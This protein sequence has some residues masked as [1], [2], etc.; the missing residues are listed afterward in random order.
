MAESIIQGLF[1]PTPYQLQQQHQAQLDAS[2]NAYAAQDPFQRATAGF[3]RAGGQAADIGAGMLGMQRPDMVE[4]QK[5]QAIFG[6]GGGL[7]TPEQIRTMAER[8]RASGDMQRSFAL[9]QLANQKEKQLAEIHKLNVET[10]PLAKIPIE[11]ATAESRKKYFA[12]GNLADLEFNDPADKMSMWAQ[13]LTDMG[14]V[15]G[16]PEFNLEMKRRWDSDVSGKS[17][18]GGTTIVMPGSE[19]PIDIQKFR[20]AVQDTLKTNLEQINAADVSMAALQQAKK[21]NFIAFQG[22]Q[23]QL[24]RA[25]SDQNISKGEVAAAGGDPSLIGAGVDYIS[26]MVSGTPSMD[27]MKKMEATLRVARKN[28]AAKSRDELKQ[29]REIGIMAGI[30]PEQLDTLLRFKETEDKQEGTSDDDLVKKWLRPTK[31]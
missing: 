24:A 28:A 26:K 3:Y 17:K 14:L 22:A 11:K 1:G 25:F 21:G 13:E 27:T 31:K 5:Q 9:I 12:T 23:Q 19:K 30:K 15:K 18:G 16:T 7:D 8:F 20:S 4:A 6:Q 29:Q 2:A 10:S